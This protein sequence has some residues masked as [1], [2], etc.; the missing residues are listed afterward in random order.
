MD[1]QN[2]IKHMDLRLL[3]SFT[4]AG[5][6]KKKERKKKSSAEIHRKCAPWVK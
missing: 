3:C 2:N 4:R 1:I 6:F 5:F